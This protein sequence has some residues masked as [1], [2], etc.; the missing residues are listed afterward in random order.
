N[1][2]NAIIAHGTMLLLRKATLVRVGGWTSETIVE[3]TELGL[4]LLATGFRTHYTNTRYGYGMLPNSVDAYRRQRQRWAHG[5]MQILRMY[6]RHLL[7]WRRELA[8]RQKG[9]FLSGWL[10]WLSDAAAA[11]LA[12]LNLLAT[13]LI[14]TGLIALPPASLV[15]PA[16]VAFAVAGL[17]TA[18]LY[19]RRVTRAPHRI[20][21]AALCAM[22]LQLV[23]A[24]SV[25]TG[26]LGR[27]LP[28]RRT[29]KGRSAMMTSAGRRTAKAEP[30]LGLLLVAAASA[31]WSTNAH[32]VWEQTLFAL[33]LAVQSLPF[34]A[35][36]VL[37]VIERMSS[38][39]LP[40]SRRWRP[41]APAGRL[42]DSPI[43]VP[44]A[45]RSA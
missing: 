31:L 35:T 4:R 3:D 25:L 45:R 42:R 24:R 11:A 30:L 41:R 32:D 16:L 23:V 1:E 21:A 39:G 9:H 37:D 6:W 17:H 22:S 7:P 13:P 40:A 43:R 27:E 36:A 26:L 34:L 19:R 8:W 38:G 29:E 12:V 28:F 5:A 44:R 10:V 20:A 14:M 18:I 15:T 2:A 33:L